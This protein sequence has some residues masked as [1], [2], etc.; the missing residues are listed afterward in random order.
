MDMAAHHAVDAARAASRATASSKRQIYSTAFFTLC[1]S[2][3]DS[4]Q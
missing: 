1:F 2:Q 3:A 4:D